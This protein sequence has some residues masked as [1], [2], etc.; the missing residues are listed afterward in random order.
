MTLEFMEYQ[1]QSSG[2]NVSTLWVLW[3]KWK[4]IIL[5]SFFI[6][7]SVC[8]H[9]ATLST[10]Q[11]FLSLDLLVTLVGIRF[12]MQTSLWTEKNLKRCLISLLTRELEKNTMPSTHFLIFM[13]RYYLH[14]FQYFFVFTWYSC[15][16]SCNMKVKPEIDVFQVGKEYMDPL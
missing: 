15:S 12:C 3:G 1:V 2:R 13:I 14:N 9:F 16:C 11:L 8:F 5:F 10:V 4:S 6:S 7:G